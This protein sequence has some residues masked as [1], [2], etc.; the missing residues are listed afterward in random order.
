[1]AKLKKET[2][3]TLKR[4]PIYT[5]DFDKV[6]SYS[7]SL[8]AYNIGEEIYKNYL[9]YA[10]KNNLKF[11]EWINYNKPVSQVNENLIP[12]NVY[13]FWQNQYKRMADKNWGQTSE[14][15]TE[16]ARNFQ[17][18]QIALQAPRYKKPVQP[19]ILEAQ[20]L[21]SIPSKEGFSNVD[22]FGIEEMYKVPI[23][24]TTLKE[25][26]HFLDV[27]EPNGKGTQRIYFDTKEEKEVFMRE[28]PMLRI[29]QNS[30]AKIKPE[31]LEYLKNKK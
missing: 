9:N 13:G 19:Y 7:D 18:E 27:S 2:V 20:D 31:T 4:N 24:K 28:N 14:K 25:P 10:N 5:T 30:V 21:E 12:K 6:K 15:T 11:D 17:K 26:E 29:G 8:N 1:M 22:D 23:K 3:E 16:E